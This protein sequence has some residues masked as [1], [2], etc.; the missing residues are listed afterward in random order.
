MASLTVATA[1]AMQVGSICSLPTADASSVS[2]L[3]AASVNLQ[4]ASSTSAHFGGRRLR[5]IAAARPSP[6]VRPSLL[7]IRAEDE[8]PAGATK[9]SSEKSTR[10][11]PD[12]GN[13]PGSFFSTAGKDLK[14][15][16]QNA[17]Q[18]VKDTAGDIADQARDVGQ[19]IGIKADQAKNQVAQSAGETTDR[20]GEEASK[21]TE[22]A[23][24]PGESIESGTD[25][26]SASAKS[27]LQGVGKNALGNSSAQSGVDDAASSVTSGLDNVYRKAGDVGKDLKN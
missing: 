22:E 23:R 13:D 14:E 26:E 10:S 9:S 2:T 25:K 1:G 21:L 19:D 17:G 20:F 15:N 18:A 4:L 6:S 24:H 27:E 16:V 5:L 12:V 7:V 3:R 11:S 8:G